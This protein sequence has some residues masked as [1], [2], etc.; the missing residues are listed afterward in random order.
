MPRHIK[1]IV[2]LSL[3]I[4]IF[5]AMEAGMQ[6]QATI[7]EEKKVF[8]TYPYSDPDPVAKP[9]RIYP[10]Y[11]FDGYSPEGADRQWAVIRMENPYI[12]VSITPEIG[13][14]VWGAREKSTGTAFIYENKV[15]KFRDIAMRGPWTS[16][17]IEFNFGAIGHAPTCSTPVDYITRQNEDGSVSCVIGAIDLPSRT[18]WRVHIRLP[19]DAASFETSSWWHNPTPLRQ[20]YYHWTNAAADISGD[21]HFHYPGN[22]HID[23]DGNAFPWP[24]DSEGRDISFYAGNTFGSHKSYHVLGQYTEFFGGYRQ[25]KD[26]GYGHWAPYHE[27]PG[28]K[29]W[30][31]ALSR[32]GEIWRDL[33]TDGDNNQYMEFQSGSLLNQAAAESSRTPFKHAFFPPFSANQWTEHWFPVKGIGGIGAASPHASMN[34]T[35]EG[36]NLHIRICPLRPLEDLLQVSTNGTLLHKQNISAA[37]MEI[38]DISIPKPNAASPYTIRIGK[39]KLLYK[40]TDAKD[41]TLNRPLETPNDFDWNSSEGLFVSA[42]EL[43]AQREY[44]KAL[45]HYLAVLEKE[46]YHRGALNAVA[47]LHYRRGNYHR[48]L[49]YCRKI[50]SINA[51]DDTANFIY[52]L[53]NKELNRMIDAKDGFGWAARS[54]T[55]RA[56]ALVQLAILHLKANRLEQALALTNQCLR[57]FPRHTGAIRLATVLHRLRGQKQEAK[58]LIKRLLEMDPLHHFANFEAFLL[59]PSEDNLRR[60]HAPIR[61]ELPHETFIE[62]ALAYLDMGQTQTA[63]QVL[64]EAPKHPL[65]N[66]WRAYLHRQ[67]DPAKSHRYLDRAQQASPHLVFP[68]RR[69]SID[70]FSWAV[71]QTRNHWKPNYYLALILWNKGRMTEA[72]EL[73]KNCRSYPDYAPFYLTRG[74]FRHELNQIER[75]IADFTTATKMEPRKWRGWHLSAQL[76]LERKNFKEALT[77]TRTMFNIAPGNYIIAL[78]HARALLRNHKL[79]ECLSVLR[80][81][82]VLPFEGAREGHDIYREAC[83]L[84]AVDHMKKSDYKRALQAVDK[85]R[86]WPENLGAGK[87]FDPDE[88]LEDH[89]AARCHKKLGRP[90]KAQDT[91]LRLETLQHDA[92]PLVKRVLRQLKKLND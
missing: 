73:F 17:G 61:N 74:T 51:Y 30:L 10:Y 90:E 13:G 55:Y 85:A 50:L 47:E 29:L 23:H 22:H 48:A 26:T 45:P 76:H 25:K 20:S 19:R 24:I 71:K 43:S 84:T 66:Y 88:R 31:W 70:I 56:P 28:K 62:L 16:G 79:R 77:A 67:T 83:L 38:I 8:K 78:D 59:D 33:L 75:A 64:A 87:P 18:Q 92:S 32:Q 1:P 6:G 2:I 41:N 53:V 63:D 40:S 68:F 39:D 14:K 42:E 57:D 5:P 7:K 89:I 37:P 91:L 34:V 65:I 44:Q 4:C 12:S 82:N 3:F 27:K 69:E 60:F 58:L 11:R 35:A 86:L 72:A 46:P 9:G 36:D 80:K 21:L 54:I 49:D 81:V 52:G 15:V